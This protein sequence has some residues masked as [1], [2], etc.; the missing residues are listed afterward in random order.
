[1][2]SHSLDSSSSCSPFVLTFMLLFSSFSYFCVLLLFVIFL[3]NK[4][5]FLFDV[6]CVMLHAS[7][8]KSVAVSVSVNLANLCLLI[9]T[10]QEQRSAIAI[11]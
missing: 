4:Y 6:F 5:F 8:P 2:Y 10:V 7:C 1:M 11:R 9:A 3:Q